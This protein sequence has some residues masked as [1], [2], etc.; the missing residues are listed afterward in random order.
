[1]NRKR[2]VKVKTPGQ[3]KPREKKGGQD[4]LASPFKGHRQVN[5]EERERFRTTFFLP[6]LGPGPERR[7]HFEDS[8]R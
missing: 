6:K 3:K 7:V 1:V 4:H 5:G 2:G 8:Q